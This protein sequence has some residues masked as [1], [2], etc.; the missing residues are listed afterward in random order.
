VAES[1]ASPAITT[2]IGPAALLMFAIRKGER[3]IKRRVWVESG[4]RAP[5]AIYCAPVSPNV[6]CV[7]TI[8]RR[9]LRLRAATPTLDCR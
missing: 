4:G 7:S 8:V 3:G 2:W 9:M 5:P 6:R 1:G